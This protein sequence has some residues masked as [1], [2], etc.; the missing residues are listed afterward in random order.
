[1][2]HCFKQDDLT[3]NTLCHLRQVSAI[4]ITT[5]TAAGLQLASLWPQAV[6]WAPPRSAGQHNEPPLESPGKLPATVYEG[7]SL[8][9]KYI[10]GIPPNSPRT[11]LVVPAHLQ[12]L[13]R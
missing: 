5:Q 12:L 7:P 3:A 2:R 4:T 1:M 11:P 13:G 8:P 6:L 9:P 10:Q